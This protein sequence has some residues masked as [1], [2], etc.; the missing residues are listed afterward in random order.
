MIV[1]SIILPILLSKTR[2]SPFPVQYYNPY[3]I[4]LKDLTVY[5]SGIKGIIKAP[6]TYD[7]KLHELSM[8]KL[9]NIASKKFGVY[10]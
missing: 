5:T 8:H 4:D 6:G 7:K 9:G 2:D 3:T 1:L 10:S